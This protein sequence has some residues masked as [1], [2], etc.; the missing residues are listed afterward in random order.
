MI[1]YY[2]IYSINFIL[3]SMYYRR[4]YSLIYS[5]MRSFIHPFTS[6][7]LFPLFLQKPCIPTDPVPLDSLNLV[8]GQEMKFSYDLGEKICIILIDITLTHTL[9]LSPHSHPLTTLTHT[10][11]LPLTPSHT[12]SPVQGPPPV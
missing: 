11:S 10:P 3:F 6:V 2:L 8:A 1:S 4:I 5:F 9:S 7:H 12:F